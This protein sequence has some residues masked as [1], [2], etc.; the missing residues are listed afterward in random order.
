MVFFAAQKAHFTTGDIAPKT[1]VPEGSGDA[2][3]RAAWTAL[4]RALFNLDE[5]VTRS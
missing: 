3:D 5:A 4:A 1:L 2:N